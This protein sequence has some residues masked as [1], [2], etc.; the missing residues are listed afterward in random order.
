MNY[1][2]AEIMWNFFHNVLAKIKIGKLSSGLCI[3]LS[4]VIFFTKSF[5]PSFHNKSLHGHL[6]HLKKQMISLHL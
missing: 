5:T 1:Q 6:Y 3:G 2:L 4:K